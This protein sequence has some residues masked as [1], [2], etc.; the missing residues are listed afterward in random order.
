MEVTNNI[1]VMSAYQKALESVK[2]ADKA[3]VES[4]KKSLETLGA[5]MVQLQEAVDQLQ[6]SG[7][8]P[9]MERP[10]D[11][12]RDQF[13][14]CIES[15]TAKLNNLQI[16]DEFK[17]VFL[18]ATD[19][20]RDHFSN[21][22]STGAASIG[23]V[24]SAMFDIYNALALMADVF[25]ELKKTSR[26]MKQIS[27]QQV[28][29]SIDAQAAKI[30]SDARV[31]MAT[32]W[33]S[34]G[35]S[36]GQIGISIGAEAFGAAGQ[37]KRGDAHGVE[38]EKKC[39]GYLKMAKNGNTS[40]LQ[41]TGESLAAKVDPRS[42]SSEMQGIA[43]GLKDN[44]KGGPVLKEDLDKVRNLADAKRADYRNALIGGDKDTI[45]KAKTEL[46][47]AENLLKLGVCRQAQNLATKPAEPPSEALKVASKEQSER[48][49][50]AI[51][52]S[53]NDKE[54][55][56]AVTYSKTAK[57]FSYIAEAMKP[58]SQIVSASGQFKAKMGEAEQMLKGKDVKKAEAQ[59][60]NAKEM[61]EDAKK[62]LESVQATLLRIVETE[63]QSYHK[64]TG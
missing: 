38:S 50:K 37:G 56:K 41:T 63:Q 46:D 29:A 13:M 11:A 18:K 14:S 45:S 5:D 51:D 36:M 30:K 32:A 48:F 34:F 40:E 25:R 24:N 58:V 60:D 9:E 23:N 47:N 19:E 10:S 43:R 35:I 16:G 31:A 28:M 55:A 8:L 57:T 26:L 49:N 59:L 54:L 2:D 7:E 22:F 3:T 44:T 4:V 6:A 39:A 15:L 42:Y 33:A 64:I 52:G 53:N 21:A 62:A 27:S 17:Q 12:S 61:Y 1:D 20:I